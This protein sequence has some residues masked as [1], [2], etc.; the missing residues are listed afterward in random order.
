MIARQNPCSDTLKSLYES[1]CL[2]FLTQLDSKSRLVMQQMIEKEILQGSTK[3]VSAKITKPKRIQNLL[4]IEGFWVTV[5]TN[6]PKVIEDYILTKS[7]KENLKD[8]CRI[9]SLGKGLPILLQGETSVGKT[10]LIQYIA[11]LAGHTCFRVNNHEHTDLSEY[12]GSYTSD[13]CGKLV[14]KEGVLVDAMRTGAWIILDEL[15]LAPTEVLEALNRVLDDNRELFIP[16]TQTTVKAHANFI[17]FATQN[18]PGRYGGRKILSRAFRNR[19]VELH[20]DQI[21]DDELVV[22]LEKRCQIPA[23]YAKKMVGSMRDLQIRRRGSDVFAGRQG[24]MTLRDLFRWGDRYRLFKDSMERVVFFDWDHRLALIGYMILAG[25]ARRLPETDDIKDVLEKRFLKNKEQLNVEEVFDRE[26][27]KLFH[28]KVLPSAFRHVVWTQ[29]MKR[30]AVLIWNALEYKEPVLL[31]GETGCGKTTLCQLYAALKNLQLESVNCHM[32][33]EGSDFLGSLRPVRDKQ[34][35]PGK[36]FEWVDGPLVQ[37]MRQGHAFLLDE[38]SLADDSVL[39]RLNSLLEPDRTLLL[40]EKAT[41]GHK[42]LEE[43]LIVKAS[44]SFLLMATMNPGGDYGKK[45]LSSAL[46]NRFTEIW[47]PSE[48]TPHDLKKIITENL[49]CQPDQKETVAAVILDF[50]LWFK[51]NVSPS[52]S[53]SSTSIRDILAW[54]NFFNTSTT[55]AIKKLAPWDA[56]LHGAYLTLIDSVGCGSSFSSESSNRRVTSNKCHEQMCQILH[57][58]QIERIDNDS[59]PQDQCFGISPFFIPLHRHLKSPLHVQNYTFDVSGV[60]TNLLKILRGMQ[61]DKPI[62]LEGVPG[63]GKTS[64]VESLAKATGHKIIR[65]NLSEQTDM[66]D[67]FGADLPVEGSNRDEDSPPSFS[68]RDGPLL[69]GLKS[70]DTWVILDELNLA[71]QSVLE[72]LNSVL[73]HRS[74]IFISELSKRFEISKEKTRIFAAQNPHGQ[75]ASRKGLPKSFLNRFTVVYIDSFTS[76]DMELILMENFIA[77]PAATISNLVDFNQKLLLNLDSNIAFGSNGA[78]FEFNLRDVSR[79]CQMI[80]S[81]MTT[82]PLSESISAA[83]RLIYSNR[84]RSISDREIVAEIFDN[85]FAFDLE[86]MPACLMVRPESISC[87]HQDLSRISSDVK[88]NRIFHLSNSDNSI[89]E[90]ILT[91]INQKWNSILIGDNDTNISSYIAMLSIMT[92][93]TLSSL[94]VHSEM[95]AIELLGGFEQSDFW[96]ILVESEAEISRQVRKN[97]RQSMHHEPEDDTRFSKLKASSSLLRSY[98]K[99]S[100]G[101]KRED[102]LE[103]IQSLKQLSLQMNLDTITER[104]NLCEKRLKKCRKLSEIGAFEWMDSQLVNSIEKGH[105]L[106]LNDANLCP[107]SVLDRLNGVLEPNGR[108]IMTEQGTINESTGL[109][110]ITPHPDFR[111]FLTMDPKNGELSR[112]MRN[113]GVEIHVENKVQTTPSYDLK[114]RMGDSI[115]YT[116]I[117]EASFLEEEPC[118]KWKSNV[119]AFLERSSESDI[120]IR[121]HLVQQCTNVD[122]LMPQLNS[123]A[124]HNHV[125]HPFDIRFD[126]M[127]WEK[128]KKTVPQDFEKRINNWHLKLFVEQVKSCCDSLT[129]LSEPLSLLKNQFIGLYSC[130]TPDD[131]QLFELKIKGLWFLRLLDVMSHEDLCHKNERLQKSVFLIH[132]AVCNEHSGKLLDQLLKACNDDIMSIGSIKAWLSSVYNCM[133]RDAFLLRIIRDVTSSLNLNQTAIIPSKI[134]MIPDDDGVRGSESFDQNVRLFWKLIWL[135]TENGVLMKNVQPGSGEIE[136]LM[137]LLPQVDLDPR[138]VYFSTRGENKSETLYYHLRQL[139]QMSRNLPSNNGLWKDGVMLDSTSSFSIVCISV[140]RALESKLSDHE[141]CHRQ[142]EQI[143][144]YLWDNYTQLNSPSKINLKVL[145]QKLLLQWHAVTSESS[146]DNK[147]SDELKVI[148]WFFH[149]NTDPFLCR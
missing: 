31:V 127:L 92:G 23:S 46:R 25:R 94:T 133:D 28:R 83:V 117:Y 4:D 39:E 122:Y 19:F 132:W 56:L 50:F 1:F 11:K 62:L 107:A 38:I 87:G 14:F 91:C 15:N 128:M 115:A 9:I 120:A 78:P 7:I 80:E 81:L 110:V 54:I 73:D 30:M 100:L 136:N 17:L 102:A 104:L 85:V 32:H 75:G 72:G 22:I 96:R 114:Y 143:E 121:Q 66:S 67:L 69:R 44:D 29:G 64:L 93:K 105:W 36:I 112:A 149:L 59:L 111:M 51:Q 148:L 65:I 6:E 82:L 125:S 101:A 18:P 95:D 37:A 74:E 27:E 20:F 8:L 16:E 40:S 13:S 60:Q 55:S 147:P 146:S 21:P 33:S 71:S 77:I 89:L 123:T 118:Q 79:C 106:L 41:E 113:R 108:L 129:G 103:S 10:S 2:S 24:F 140:L 42:G 3:I 70:D 47:C 119:A 88:D 98:Q 116:A 34:L 5:G 142:I 52:T 49:S 84:F 58:Y 144:T 130:S 109:R 145:Y 12:I 126:H 61:L 48:V 68:W 43:G 26:F 139:D 45:E 90:S 63:V 137:S 86:L 76:Q 99:R 97:L 138:H 131:Q 134:N 35:N 135:L 141:K 124:H 57:K 53:K